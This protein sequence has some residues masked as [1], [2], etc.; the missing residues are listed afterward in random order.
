MHKKVMVI[1]DN[2][3]DLFVADFVLK[4]S[5]FA[6]KVICVQSAREALDYLVNFE[7]FPDELPEFIF[8]DI[9]MPLMSGFDFLEEY[10]KLSDT[11]KKHCIIMM[12]TTSLNEKDRLRAEENKYVCSFMNK[13]LNPE[14]VQ[15]IEMRTLNPEK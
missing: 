14:K 12:L 4:K 13:P 1:D 11:I 3:V 15:N 2:E 5:S 9:N 7:N 10:E 6:E 8:L